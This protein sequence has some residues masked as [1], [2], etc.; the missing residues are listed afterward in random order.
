MASTSFIAFEDLTVKFI[1]ITLLLLQL[2]YNKSGVA[3]LLLLLVRLGN[4]FGGQCRE[5]QFPYCKVISHRDSNNFSTILLWPLVGLG[6]CLWVRK[7]IKSKPVFINFLLLFCHWNLIWLDDAVRIVPEI[8]LV[9]LPRALAILS[10]INMRKHSISFALL[11]GITLRPFSGIVFF[12]TIL[13]YHHQYQGA[14]NGV[15]RV[16][17]DY[18]NYLM[19]IHLYFVTGHQWTFTSLQWEAAFIGIRQTITQISALLMLLN[20]MAGPLTIAFVMKGKSHFATYQMV[21]LAIFC[22]TL[23]YHLMIWR[24]FTPRLLLQVLMTIV[25]CIQSSSSNSV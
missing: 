20:T 1:L 25:L 16:W 6:I 11:V 14:A 12:L 13:E 10:L 24:M 17:N 18:T 19:A 3:L 15:N 5:E 23:R 22:S 8:V 9:Y 21:G 7:R 4:Y 2:P